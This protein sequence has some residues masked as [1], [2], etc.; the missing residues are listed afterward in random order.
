MKYSRGDIVLTKFSEKEFLIIGIES[1]FD[2]N[3]YH[4]IL[5]NNNVNYIG[6]WPIRNINT[7]ENIDDKFLNKTA[8]YVNEKEIIHKINDGKHCNIC[9]DIFTKTLKDVNFTCWACDV[10]V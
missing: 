1:H 2:T 8:R 4:Y 3:N 6:Y 10:N 5:L 9:F 7:C